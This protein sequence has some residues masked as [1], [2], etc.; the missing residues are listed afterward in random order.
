[1]VEPTENFQSTLRK[2]IFVVVM[3]ARVLPLLLFFELQYRRTV[4]IQGCEENIQDVN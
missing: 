4:S 1:M 3:V 2:H